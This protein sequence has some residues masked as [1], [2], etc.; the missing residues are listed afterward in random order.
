M[1]EPES[2]MKLV[3]K[4]QNVLVEQRESDPESLAVTMRVVT[5]VKPTLAL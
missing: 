2:G 3:G 1:L 5:L 4:D